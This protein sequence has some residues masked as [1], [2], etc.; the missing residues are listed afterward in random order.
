MAAAPNQVQRERV[1]YAL[2]GCSG[3]YF[4]FRTFIS[5]LRATLFYKN[6]LLPWREVERVLY[7]I[8]VVRCE[9]SV[10]DLKCSHEH[11][12]CLSIEY[13][14]KWPSSQVVRCNVTKNS[15]HGTQC[16][17]DATDVFQRMPEYN[18]VSWTDFTPERMQQ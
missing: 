9:I 4:K 14:A 1:P 7:K 15:C 12:N 11:R 16:D 10:L 13:V 18:L 2:V 5:N 8:I 17:V 3:V 6:S